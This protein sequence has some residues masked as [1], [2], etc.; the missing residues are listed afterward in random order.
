MSDFQAIRAFLA[1]VGRR[2]RIAY[3]LAGLGRALATG[4]VVL[5]GVALVLARTGAR[6]HAR[7]IG[8]ILITLGAIA[9]AFGAWR[10]AWRLRDPRAVARHVGGLRPALE[11]DLLS[12]LELEREAT[13]PAV[14]FSRDLL[15]AFAAET[16]NHTTVEDPG[17]LG[18][19]RLARKTSLLV[20]VAALGAL[21]LALFF[22]PALKSGLLVL[23]GKVQAPPVEV[24][25]EP[26]IGDL[27][28]TYT[29]PAYTALPPQSVEGSD[30][31]LSAL[32]GTTVALHARSLF[33]I[34]AAEI[35][36]SDGPIAVSIKDGRELD[37][38]IT[39]RRSGSYHFVLTR[40]D[41]NHALAE[42]ADHLI[43]VDPDRPPQA[44]LEAP[45][46][47]LEVTASQKIQLRY[48]IADDFGLSAADLVY[49]VGDAPE[50]RQPLSLASQGSIAVP[51]PASMPA[52]APFASGPA[53]RSAQGTIDWDL[54]DLDLGAGARVA[55]RVEAK[56]NDVVLG[57][58][59]GSS[60]T[61]YVHIYS[62]RSKHAQLLAEEDALLTAAINVL[63]DRLEH[64][65]DPNALAS[66]ADGLDVFDGIHNESSSLVQQI[67]TVAT[68]AAADPVAAKS[69]AS[70]LRAMADRLS[71]INHDE[72]AAL[73]G[74]DV[75]RHRGDTLP[76]SGLDAFV[77]AT[78][79][80]TPEMEQDVLQLDDLFD[81]EKLADLQTLG[82]E[83]QKKRD[84]IKK[85]LDE[86]QKT[87]DPAT[88]AQI[89]RDLSG[90]EQMIDEFEKLRSSMVGELP[91]E[92]LNTD[93]LAQSDP[94]GD[95]EKMRQELDKDDVDSMERDLASL[96][97]KL[98]DTMQG[99]G[100][101]MSDMSDSRFSEQQKALSALMDQLSDLQQ[102][103]QHVGDESQKILD[104]Y[105][106]AAEAAAKS[107]GGDTA[108]AQAS[109]AQLKKDIQS[110]DGAPMSAYDREAE[111]RAAKHADQAG[112]LMASGD[113]GDASQLLRSAQ[114]DLQAVAD[115]EADAAAR[116][117]AGSDPT[118][119]AQKDGEQKASAEASSAGDEAG[120]LADALQGAMPSPEDLLSPADREALSKLSAEQAAASKRAGDVAQQAQAES[121][122]SGAFGPDV[123]QGI[124][125]AQ[126]DMD[127]SGA[128]LGSGEPQG[129]HDSAEDAAQKLADLRQKLGQQQ[130]SAGAVA[131]GGSGQSG[132]D[133]EEVKIPD[134]QQYKAP[135]EFRQDILDAMKQEAPS[136]YK[137]AVKQYYEE[138]VK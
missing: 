33:P 45:A 11:S 37:A 87:H 72:D 98:D 64:S 129:G 91:D 46:P 136:A 86:Y 24:A 74:L 15:G 57:P 50:K 5:L 116:A 62:P 122:K 126:S 106:S 65:V 12:A 14:R 40:A 131:A 51:A 1:R 60:R 119:A 58:N 134:A 69:L 107:A 105:K 133:E 99:L 90:L 81:R 135:K 113:L 110:L 23:T 103:E 121:E 34:S 66:A 9:A 125:G 123:A 128:H 114:D 8:L 92:F 53:P 115:D 109:L 2:V 132:L 68:D 79:E 100:Q 124:S 35:Q 84:E 36:S 75:A 97:K 30:G 27:D 89:E 10:A 47:D 111:Q 118:E 112:D 73:A 61:F 56:D 43:E 21:L 7:M 108:K 77:H 44:D 102:E 93:S 130:G 95:L 13:A 104:R 71:A 31:D 67:G 26:I 49:R 54:G 85:L 3:L 29:Y 22:A 88:K 78:D 32:P 38:T 138:L 117:T 76:P 83:I 63:G 6:P 59:T 137:D 17:L 82:A 70:T 120:K 39:V 48:A 96:S 18:P 25:Y 42:P 101:G 41:D 16:A 20:G 80:A 94:S 19:P 28:L 127:R 55:Y 52:S 4:L